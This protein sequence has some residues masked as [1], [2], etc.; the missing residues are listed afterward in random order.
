[1][2]LGLSLLQK[3]ASD[4]NNNESCNN[5]SAFVCVC[6]RN[7]KGCPPELITEAKY[8]QSREVGIYFPPVITATASTAVRR[9]GLNR[10]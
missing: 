4:P 9:C 6:V 7:L 3:S 5:E 1:M 10:G 2:T 8:F